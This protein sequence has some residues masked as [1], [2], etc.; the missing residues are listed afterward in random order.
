[1]VEEAIGMPPLPTPPEASVALALF[2]ERALCNIGVLET[3]PSEADGVAVGAVEGTAAVAAA[4]A[5]GGPVSMMVSSIT[6]ASRLAPADGLTML[7]RLCCT[8]FTCTSY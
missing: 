1:M 6:L 5:L 2:P 4:A 3:A 8:S 7:F